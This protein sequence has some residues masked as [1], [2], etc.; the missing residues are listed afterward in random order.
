LAWHSLPN[1]SGRFTTAVV[2]VLV[3]MAMVSSHAFSRWGDGG[4]R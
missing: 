1:V 3:L 4:G 2:L